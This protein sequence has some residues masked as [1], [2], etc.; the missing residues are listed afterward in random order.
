MFSSIFW[1]YCTPV[2]LEVNKLLLEVCFW[3]PSLLP[4]N[5]LLKKFLDQQF[6]HFNFYPFFPYP[7]LLY[8]LSKLFLN[9]IMV[10]L[11][12]LNVLTSAIKVKLIETLLWAYC[13]TKKLKNLM[14]LSSKCFTFP[15]RQH[16]LGSALWTLVICPCAKKICALRDITC[17]QCI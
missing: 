12:V 1:H 10:L 5:P 13:N 16:H 11:A 17:A 8:L 6:S 3:M 15:C 2:L 9:N 7:K 14:R 4:H